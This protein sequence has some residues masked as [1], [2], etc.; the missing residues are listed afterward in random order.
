MSLSHPANLAMLDVN[1]SMIKSL[2]KA[3]EKVL[4]AIMELLATDADKVLPVLSMTIALLC[5]IPGIG[6]FLNNF[7]HSYTY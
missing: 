4:A 2:T 5:S 1:I 3:L 7:F 6:L